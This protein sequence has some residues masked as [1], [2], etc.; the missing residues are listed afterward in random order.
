MSYRIS[1]VS[2]ITL[3]CYN[4]E[5]KTYLNARAGLEINRTG[6]DFPPINP[7]PLK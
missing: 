2:P 4:F 3:S 5:F 6:L 1:Q 7:Y